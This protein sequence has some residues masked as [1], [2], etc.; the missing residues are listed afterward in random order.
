VYWS[1]ITSVTVRGVRGN[2][3]KRAKRDHVGRLEVYF[4]MLRCGAGVCTIHLWTRLSFSSI[5]STSIACLFRPTLKSTLFRLTT[6]STLIVPDSARSLGTARQRTAGN[7][8]RHSLG[9]VALGSAINVV[10]VPHLVQL[11]AAIVV[12]PLA[13]LCLVVLG[14]AAAEVG[15]DAV[16]ASQRGLNV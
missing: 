2:R 8:S 14:T 5:H 11:R 3:K 4:M 10:V 13:G 1:F 16:L 9:L 6:R 15:N 7:I 12:R